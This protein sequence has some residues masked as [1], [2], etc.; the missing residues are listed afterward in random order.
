MAAVPLNLSIEQG[1]DFEVTFTVRKKDGTPLNL[2]SYTAESKLRK[3][4]D[5][6]N[7]IPF[8]VTFI[9]RINGKISI[10]MSNMTTSN[11]KEGRNVYDV[12]LT[13]PNEKKSRF[14]YGSIIVSPGV[15]L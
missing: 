10:S 13:S 15:S 1:T 14:I 4:Y 9:D 12:V 3:H 7:F 6:P 8:V 2:L 5:S 11:L